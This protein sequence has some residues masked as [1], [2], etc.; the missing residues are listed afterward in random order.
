[1]LASASGISVQAPVDPVT[2][3]PS[4]EDS[5]SQRQARHMIRKESSSQQAF[6]ARRLE[7]SLEQQEELSLEHEDDTR[8]RAGAEELL[9]EPRRPPLAVPAP[10][11]KGMGRVVNM[12]LLTTM[13]SS[14]EEK[15]VA[16]HP[17]V[18]SWHLMNIHNWGDT[19]EK[20]DGQ[21]SYDAVAH[22]EYPTVMKIE[23]RPDQ[24]DKQFKVGLTNHQMD[25]P[26]YEHGCYLGFFD[27]GRLFM[28]GS[29]A[30]AKE[31][32][33]MT[34]S[35]HDEFGISVENG[36]CEITRNGQHLTSFSRPM[37][38]P[39]TVLIFMRDLHAKCQITKMYVSYDFGQG[40]TTIALANYGPIGKI[41][42]PGLPGPPGV[43]GQAGPPGPPATYE[44]M[45]EAA[46]QGPLGP[47]GEHGPPGPEGPVGPP[48]PSGPRGPVGPTGAIPEHQSLMWEAT[49]KELDDAIKKAA[50]MDRSERMKLD[51]RMRNVDRHL[52]EVSLNLQQQEEIAR[53]AAEAE[54]AERKAA[55]EAAEKAAEEAKALANAKATDAILE[56]DAQS[57]KNKA[58]EEIEDATGGTTDDS[59]PT[60]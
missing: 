57:T 2:R 1:M 56:S 35:T 13:A 27:D 36:H 9:L 17:L 26:D 5:A 16:G 52:D 44:M 47:E 33:A 29:E 42:E 22:T 20:I 6:S 53:K 55:L 25:S 38:A 45:F 7:D 51:A 28:S 59:S 4:F 23:V 24:T 21:P 43:E 10:K 58:I 54:E 34:Y 3:A 19:L 39:A 48:G 49:I 40:N 37:K 14:E 46:P 12:E 11:P 60:R 50:D 15:K 30:A 31:D 41:G 32:V 8:K 18:A